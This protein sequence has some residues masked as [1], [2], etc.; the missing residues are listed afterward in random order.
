VG[1]PTAP[2]SDDDGAVDIEEMLERLPEGWS[3][4]DYRGRRYGVTRTTHLDGRTVSV[5]AEEL[6]GTDVVSA[7]A[8]RTT[9]GV[10]VRPC[11]MPVE[12]VTEF[13]SGWS[14]TPVREDDDS[15]VVV[16][17]AQLTEEPD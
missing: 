15:S 11:E 10:V 14:P 5:Y 3:E 9:D 16:I 4:V 2:A 7:N 8:Y 12:K 13:L 6:G 1:E 17:R